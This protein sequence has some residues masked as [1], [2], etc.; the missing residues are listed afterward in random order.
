[1]KSRIAIAKTAFNK[2]RSFSTSK[3]D[4]NLREKKQV[5]CYIWNIA[6]YGVETWTLWKLDQ[7]YLE[8]FEMW[9][10]KTMEKISWTERVRDEE[11]LY[12]VKEKRNVVHTIKRR[13]ANWIFHA[14]RR[15]RLLQHITER[16]KGGIVVRG[17]RR[18]RRKQI[19]DDRK[20]KKGYWKLKGEVLNRT[21]WRTRFGRE[22]RRV[23]RDCRMNE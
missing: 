14:L 11:V 15:N 8:S 12:R 17:R 2:N 4:L 3:L 13:K 7:E 1:M 9:C 19:L 22:C 18:I 16:Q 20:E 23:V 5:K 21:V 6:L 10:W